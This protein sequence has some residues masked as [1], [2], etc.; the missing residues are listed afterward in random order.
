MSLFI[1]SHA[2]SSLSMWDLGT[3]PLCYKSKPD[4]DFAYIIDFVII[5]YNIYHWLLLYITYII[6]IIAY[7]I[8]FVILYITCF[9]LF[10]NPPALAQPV[11]LP[12]LPHHFSFPPALA[13]SGIQSSFPPAPVWIWSEGLKQGLQLFITC[14]KLKQGF[15]ANWSPEQLQAAESLVEAEDLG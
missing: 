13:E 5:V 10:A 14:P 12:S 3:L 1:I 15:E 6:V 4:I 11:S 2:Y 7:I 9:S 8:D